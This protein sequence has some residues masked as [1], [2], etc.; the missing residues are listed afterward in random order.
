M[1][2]TGLRATTVLPL[3]L[4]FVQVTRIVFKLPSFLG[5]RHMS[6]HTAICFVSPRR[7]F[8]LVFFG[9]CLVSKS[10]IVN[11][12]VSCCIFCPCGFLLLSRR[13]VEIAIFMF[14]VQRGEMNTRAVLFASAEG[15]GDP[16]RC[17]CPLENTID[18]TFEGAEQR[19]NVFTV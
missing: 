1:K 12:R 8:C 15:A 10:I 16:G 2:T 9:Q 7:E 3:L 14:I 4:P 18:L 19:Y 6:G 17:S 5:I 11:T 13:G